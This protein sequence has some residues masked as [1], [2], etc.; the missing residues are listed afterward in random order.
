MEAP[1]PVQFSLL[2]SADE[3]DEHGNITESE[4]PQ[5]VIRNKQYDYGAT[6][7]GDQDLS[8]MASVNLTES[9]R[10]E[11]EQQ[12]IGNGFAIPINKQK[13]QSRKKPSNSN[14]DYHSSAEVEDRKESLFILQD[15]IPRDEADIS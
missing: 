4:Q 7:R 5:Y 13:H 3:M 6:A 11:T 1:L 12:I 2:G 8:P 10:F 9:K 15:K 14:D